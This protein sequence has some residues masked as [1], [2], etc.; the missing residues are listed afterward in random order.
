MPHSSCTICHLSQNDP[1]PLFRGRS[2]K[3]GWSE[4]HP[5]KMRR[6]LWKISLF[7]SFLRVQWKSKGRDVQASSSLCR[8]WPNH[9]Y[10]NRWSHLLRSC[11]RS[12]NSQKRLC[13]WL[14]VNPE[15]LRN[16]REE[17][18]HQRKRKEKKRER[19][20]IENEDILPFK[21]HFRACRTPQWILAGVLRLHN[22]QER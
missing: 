11:R 15:E 17:N 14:S 22:H 9:L 18:P 1:Q 21:P 7:F 5:E 2:P 3:W 20:S 16:Q 13:L 6:I 4:K 8:R 19:C 10:C 12:L